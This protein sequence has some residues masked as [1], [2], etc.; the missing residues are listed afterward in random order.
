MGL[1]EVV[2]LLFILSRKCV[3]FTLYFIGDLSYG[4]SKLG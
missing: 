2:Y 3:L 1:I 4:K